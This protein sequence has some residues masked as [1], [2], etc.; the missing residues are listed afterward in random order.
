MFQSRVAFHSK[1]CGILKKKIVKEVKYDT[2]VMR[3]I[4]ESKVYP[5]ILILSYVVKL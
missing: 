4:G 5:K 1:Q 3:L 2:E